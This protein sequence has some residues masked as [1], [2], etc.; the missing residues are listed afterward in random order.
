MIYLRLEAVVLDHRTATVK[1][2]RIMAVETKVLVLD[3]T[4][5]N[6]DLDLVSLGAI[7]MLVVDLVAI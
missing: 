3:W 2:L 1:V 4:E 7:R 6:Q 5:A